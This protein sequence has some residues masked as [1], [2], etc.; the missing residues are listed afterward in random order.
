MTKLTTLTPEQSEKLREHL[1]RILHVRSLRAAAQRVGVSAGH[2]SEVVAGRRPITPEVLRKIARSTNTDLADLLTLL[3]LKVD[4]RS[5]LAAPDVEEGVAT[6]SL[7]TATTIELDV[8]RFKNLSDAILKMDASYFTLYRSVLAAF[9][10][11]AGKVDAFF[12]PAVDVIFK[13]RQETVENLRKASDDIQLLAYHALLF[14][15]DPVEYV[16]AGNLSLRS[17]RSLVFPT[18]AESTLRKLAT[19]GWQ[20]RGNLGA[21]QQ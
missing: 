17:L 6:S 21:T 3:D 12:I 15:A 8:E 9:L 10:F 13:S 2:F 14:L 16:K 5:L 11:A 18:E 19:E 20:Q 1:F 7:Q 4:D